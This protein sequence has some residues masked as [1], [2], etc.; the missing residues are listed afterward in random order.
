MNVGRSWIGWPAG[1]VVGDSL[2]RLAAVCAIGQPLAWIESPAGLPE[3]RRRLGSGVDRI[4]PGF[5]LGCPRLMTSGSITSM[6]SPAPLGPEFLCA[7]RLPGCC[8][9]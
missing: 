1:G 5:L 3:S 9:V 6:G 4:V 8:V 2:A 7:G